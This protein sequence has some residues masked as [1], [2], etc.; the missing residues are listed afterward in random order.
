MGPA[1]SVSSSTKTWSNEIKVFRFYFEFLSVTFTSTEWNGGW[2]AEFPW[3]L[4][5]RKCFGFFFCFRLPDWGSRDLAIWRP[6]R[7]RSRCRRCAS[8]TSGTW[9]TAPA[10]SR[11]RRRS[12]PRRRRRGAAAGSCRW[13]RCAPPP[14]SRVRRRGPAPLWPTPT[15]TGRSSTRRDWRR[16]RRRG[17]AAAATPTA[18]PTLCAPSPAAMA[19]PAPALPPRSPAA[20]RTVQVFCLSVVTLNLFKFDCLGLGPIQN[21]F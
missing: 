9:S 18:T 5:G 19:R 3:K 2:T 8:A 12:A 10:S 15:P 13:R 20:A 6:G 21:S 11:R 7:R 14:S 4:G 16:R 1:A 17:P